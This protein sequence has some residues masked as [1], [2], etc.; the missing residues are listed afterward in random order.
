[1]LESS[2][3]LDFSSSRIIY[4]KTSGSFKIF[5]SS[6]LCLCSWRKSKAK[7]EKH[8]QSSFKNSFESP[9]S[10][11]S[12]TFASSRD[13]NLISTRL[14]NG[15]PFHVFYDSE[16]CVLITLLLFYLFILKLIRQPFDKVKKDLHAFM[17]K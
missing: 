16:V 11:Y 6:Y 2:K 17:L 14:A 9:C 15:E 3:T 13:M 8:P 4:K 5:S 7:A 1:M 10:S 12:S